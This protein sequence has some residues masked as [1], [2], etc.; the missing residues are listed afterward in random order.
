[1]SHIEGHNHENDRLEKLFNI[2]K[3][4]LKHKPNRILA[5]TYSDYLKTGK[6]YGVKDESASLPH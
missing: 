6:L 2:V 3:R 1:M 4:V 5:N